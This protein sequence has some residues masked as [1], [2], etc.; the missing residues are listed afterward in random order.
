MN[1]L[2][3]FLEIVRKLCVDIQQN[4]YFYFIVSD[5]YKKSFQQQC[6]STHKQNAPAATEYS[7]AADALIWQLLCLFLPLEMLQAHSYV[8]LQVAVEKLIIIQ[9][10]NSR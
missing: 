1:F 4:N 6:V 10:E 2:T 3:V 8:L 5:G 7:P 9:V